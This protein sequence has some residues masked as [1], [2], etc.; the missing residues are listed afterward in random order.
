MLLSGLPALAA[1]S[2]FD[3]VGPRLDV[4]ITR[5]GVTLPLEWV[6]NLAEGDRVSIR[7]DLPPGQSERYLMVAAFLRGATDRPPDD[8]FHEARSWKAKGGGLSLV[9]PKGAQQ[10]ALLLVPESGGDGDAVVGA[11][12]K[13]PGAFVRAVQELNQASLD[14]ARLDTF[15]QGMQQAQRNGPDAITAASQTLTRSLSIKL[16]GE[17]LQLPVEMQA[18]CLTEDRETLLL[19]DTHSS[20]LAD[21]IVGAPTDLALQLSATP[22][23]GYGLYSS[24]IGVVRDLFRLFG[25]FQSTQL[26]F[27]PALARAGGGRVTLLLNT[28]LSFSKPT[29]VMVA[30][31]P[32]VE[33]SKPPPLRRSDSDAPLCAA[34]DQV[35][36]VE[37]APLVY[38]TRYARNMTLRFERADGQPAEVPVHADPR[39]GGFVID[40]PLPPTKGANIEA[41]LHG[42]WGFTPF[43]G[44]VFALSNP[45]ANDWRATDRA[46]LVVGRANDL[47]LTGGAAGCVT[48]VEMRSGDGPAQAVKWVR[49][50]TEDI[51][52]TLPLEKAAPGP[53]SVRIAGAAGSTPVSVT[54]P[55]LQEAG[56]LG[57]LSY[58][59]GDAEAVLSGTRLDQVR[60]VTL[61]GVPFRPGVLT[62]A[63]GQDRLTLSTADPAKPLPLAAG[64]A[65]TADV[66]FADGRQARLATTIAPSRATATLVSIAGQPPVRDG[67]LPI[68]I[69]SDGVFA[70]NARLTFAFRLNGAETL[71]GRETV[72]IGTVDGRANARVEAGKGYDLQDAR[73]GIVTFAP[74]TTL[75]PLASGPLRF[76]VVDEQGASNWT[77]LATVARLPEIRSIACGPGGACALTG[78]RLFLIQA[79]GATDRFEQAQDVPDGFT[80]G[81][82]TLPPGVK[83]QVF[84]RLRDAP[85]AVAAVRA[86]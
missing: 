43:E 28:P 58:H 71:T 69:R 18:A 24:Y 77:R 84:L 22:Q 86:P 49:S 79:V 12:R 74:A 57:T 72:E 62:R 19:A 16:K 29:S 54:V 45:Q 14:R 4:A 66:T 31:L 30:A 17:C 78:D 11:V 65:V 50:G 40:R 59:A 81:E 76:R 33:A 9:V 80:A 8:W 2:S 6:P 23:A 34:R 39:R 21:T 41:R 42:D 52:A 83:E 70:Q 61:G 75:G 85:Q 64:T 36:P 32:A 47:A 37:G 82:L 63:D 48:G 53:V 67:V 60:A 68:E 15:L 13:Q 35:L 27:V 25:A 3:L 51:V 46:S 56:G 38:A 44:P 10:L 5:G 55:A 7:L 20:A 73:T 1:P 26:Q